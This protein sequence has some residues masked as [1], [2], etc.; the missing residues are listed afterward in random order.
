MSVKSFIWWKTLHVIRDRGIFTEQ[1]LCLHWTTMIAD[2]LLGAER[3]IFQSLSTHHILLVFKSLTC[4]FVNVSDNHFSI[5]WMSPS[6]SCLQWMLFPCVPVVSL[7][8][9][10]TAYCLLYKMICCYVGWKA[11]LLLLLLI[12]LLLGR[13]TALATGSCCLL[14]QME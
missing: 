9:Q 12:L 3:R 10:R 5:V 4:L 2:G 11:V 13:M 1:K 8:A 6:T 7:T 14:L